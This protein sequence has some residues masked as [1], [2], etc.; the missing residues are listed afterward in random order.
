MLVTP[1]FSIG[2]ISVKVQPLGIETVN[3]NEQ[4]VTENDGAIL[5]C[6]VCSSFDCVKFVSENAAVRLTSFAAKL[7]TLIPKHI[8]TSSA[9]VSRSDSPFAF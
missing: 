4:I 6:T 5:R 8:E 3:S 9:N 2:L 1:L 7:V